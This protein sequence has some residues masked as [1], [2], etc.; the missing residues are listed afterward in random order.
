MPPRRID[1]CVCFLALSFAWT[2]ESYTFELRSP[3]YAKPG[4]QIR[5]HFPVVL[6][7]TPGGDVDT[8]EAFSG[9]Y[10]DG[11]SHAHSGDDS[12]EALEPPVLI[13]SA[14]NA[15]Q[16]EQA[17][18]TATPFFA[19][20][21]E[22]KTKT[23]PSTNI[24]TEADISRREWLERSA[25]LLFGG[26]IVGGVIS[27]SAVENNP[28]PEPVTPGAPSLIPQKLNP[29]TKVPTAKNVLG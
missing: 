19:Y 18:T 5:R 16:D 28:R 15:I 8:A 26:V 20:V 6:F 4:I 22:P 14:E 1:V 27:Q 7:N 13:D 12:S 9:D 25:K 3:T 11:T 17:T 21:V 24:T 10:T 29:I 2:F 23:R